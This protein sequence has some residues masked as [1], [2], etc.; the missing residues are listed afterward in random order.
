MSTSRRFAHMLLVALGAAIILAALGYGAYSYDKV[1]AENSALT[2][3]LA[4]S[5]A[6]TNDLLD[7]LTAASSTIDTFTSQLGDISSTVGT[8]QKRVETDPQLLEKYSKVFFLNENYVPKGLA[9]ISTALTYNGKSLQFLSQAY[10]FL[11]NLMSAAQDAGLHLFVESSYRSFGEQSELKSSYKVTY[12]SGSANSFSAD[13]GYSE[14]QLGTAVDFTTL[15]LK[16]GLT[17]FD[18]TPEY[19]WLSAN[20]YKYGFVLSYP[21]GNTYYIYEPWHWRF[22]GIALATRLHE[23]RQNFYDLEQRQID[24]YL[25]KLFDTE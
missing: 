4:L 21:A 3:K 17:G 14:H 13:Q 5:E 20:A 19:A 25:V 23:E 6:Q 2:E 22:V 16:G 10:P 11:T 9:D 7:K 15:S 8:L 1:R 12:G 18:K 24:P